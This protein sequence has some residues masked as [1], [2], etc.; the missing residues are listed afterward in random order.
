MRS[1]SVSLRSRAAAKS[2]KPSLSLIAHPRITCA[3]SESQPSYFRNNPLV[4]EGGE[5]RA[6]ASNE[7]GEGS[8]PTHADAR[9]PH[10]PRRLRPLGTLSHKGRGKAR[11]LHPFLNS[12]G[13]NGEPS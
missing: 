3:P 11:P 12:R 9:T 7:P 1:S 4:G 13:Q 8:V 10:P 2:P 6:P 5:L